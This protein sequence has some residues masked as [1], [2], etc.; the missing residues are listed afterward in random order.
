MATITWIT[1]S[2]LI[3]VYPASVAMSVNVVAT[4]TG[5][6]IIDYKI[7]S[8]SLPSGLSFRSD[9]KIYGTPNLVSQDTSSTFV[10]RVTASDNSIKDRTFILTI[11]GE[12]NPFITTTA[13]SLPDTPLNDSTWYEYAIE[14]TNPI[15][16]NPVV[17]RIVEGELPPGLEMNEFGLIRGYADPPV[18]TVTLPEI[19]TFATLTNSTNDYITVLSTEDFIINRPIIFTGTAFGGIVATDVYYI[20]EIINATQITISEI[21]NGDVFSVTNGSGVLTATLPAIDTGEPTKFEYTFTVE[22]S[23]PLGNDRESYSMVII[24]QNLPVSQGGPGFTAGTRVPTIFNTRPQTFNIDQS[25][26][27]YGYYVLPPIDQV[28]VPGTTYDPAQDANMG[29][30]ISGNY[31]SFRI[32]GYDFDNIN[33]SYTFTGTLP[34]GLTANTSTGW[35]YGDPT[36]S[37]NNIQE[38][39]FDVKVSKTVGATVINSPTF[40]FKFQ[41]ANNITGQIIWNTNSDLG[42]FYNA[43]LSYQNIVAESDVALNYK[44][45]SGSLPP[46][47]ELQENGEITGIISYQPANTYQEANTAY[48]FEFEVNAYAQSTS[49]SSIVNS[50]KTFNMS[51]IQKY[52]QPTDNLYIKCTPPLEDR[53][54][55]ESLLGNTSLIPTEYLYRPDDA[56]FGKAQ[57]V[58]YAHAYG[59]NSSNIDEYIA[60]VEKNHYWRNITLGS[61]NT[62]I[63]KDINGN[64][65]YEVVYSNIIDNLL[66]YDPNYGVDYRYAISIPEEIFWP[67]FIDLNLGPWYSSN[68]EIY[69]SYIFAQNAYII[70]NFTEYNILTQDGIPLLI[71]QGIPT[72][73]TSLTPGYAR[74]L[75]PNSLPNMRDR[76]EQELGTSDKFDKLPLWMTS[77]QSDGNT[78]G[79]TPAWVICYT[80]PAPVVDVV[81][82]QTVKDKNAVVVTSLE[83]IIVGGTIVF[84]GNT[85]GNVLSNQT[86]YVK[87]IGVTGYPMGI[88]LSTTKNGPAYELIDD[89]GTMNGEFTVGSYAELIKNN[90]ESN[91]QYTLN[92]IDFQI[93]RFTV[94]KQITYDFDT[95]FDPNVWT[96]YPS[97]D[98]VPDPLDSENF[99]VLFPRQTILPDKTQYNL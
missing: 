44:I 10:V 14:Y 45:E 57:D 97:A 15:S 28:S 7:I 50:T 48:S 67:R 72:F 2:G 75:Y 19:V 79:F 73:Y 11:S 37:L 4:V 80:K 40:N 77:Q 8:G 6:T 42:N 63:A 84:F 81:C 71:N 12:A 94:D 74:I 49:L 43:S 96:S 82:T 87:T 34:A 85:F 33:L 59:I 24:N 93:D 3:G 38:F 51:V 90:I 27:N 25:T 56:N 17:F 1:T 36:V 46:N 26:L 68:T 98:P 18:I 64:V 21:P 62:A 23:S 70:T 58:V 76:I 52:E 78:L 47:L 22:L 54:I 88:V 61:L 92:K 83:N 60:A 32:L 65:V 95:M 41:V 53:L 5:G 35:I 55:I 39:S 86:Y 29:Q 69:S 30:F 89:S 91:W 9:G 13:G 99:Y 66:K 16:T 20:K 31:F